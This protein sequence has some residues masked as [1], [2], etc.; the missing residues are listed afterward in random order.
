ETRASTAIEAFEADPSS[1]VLVD[2][3]LPDMPGISL[4]SRLK[5]TND[6][7]AIIVVTAM[8]NV[9]TSVEA[10]QKGAWDY[11]VKEDPEVLAQRLRTAVK[12][13]WRRRITEAQQQLVEQTRLR[14][15]VRAERLEA[16]EL[17][18]RTVC[19]EVN[20]PL[21]GVVALSQLLQQSGKLDQEVKKLADGIADSAKQVRTAIDKLR[22]IDDTVIEFGGQKILNSDQQK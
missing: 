2:L 21:S 22:S 8:D 4:L 18:V 7:A 9:S 17:V 1:I 16:I 14:E 20:N 3:T 11:V 13:A 10:M 15:M 5:S 19:H 12:S 6:R